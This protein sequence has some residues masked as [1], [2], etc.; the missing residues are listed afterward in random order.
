VLGVYEL[1]KRER[2]MIIIRMSMRKLLCVVFVGR[3]V[4]LDR[5]GY[6]NDVGMWG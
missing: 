6:E 1:V 3:C 5:G 4:V 2:F